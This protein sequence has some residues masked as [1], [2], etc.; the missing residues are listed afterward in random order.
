MNS[1]ER[2]MWWVYW[3][4]VKFGLALL[5]IKC[6]VFM[7]RIMQ[8][9]GCNLAQKVR[10]SKGT[11]IKLIWKCRNHVM[12][13]LKFCKTWS[14]CSLDAMQCFHAQKMQASG[15]NLAQN[16]RWSNYYKI[17][18]I[19]KCWWEESLSL[20]KFYKS[21]SNFHGMQYNIFV[22]RMIQASRSNLAQNVRWSNDARWNLPP[23][24]W[25]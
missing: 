14:S 15:C 7:L 17:R 22:L 23:K 1:L 24:C 21:W 20:L 2:I 13:P 11:K 8:A 9:L 12:G 6:N 16:M 4:F 5:W 3:N 18:R 10:W 19:W 25:W